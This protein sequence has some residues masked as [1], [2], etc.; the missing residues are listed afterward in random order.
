MKHIRVFSFGSGV[1][2]VAVLALQKLHKLPKPYDY[3]V[4]ANV[5]NDSESP[6]TLQYLNDIVRPRGACVC[7]APSEIGG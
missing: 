3:F 6:D 5:G 7:A 2:S 1:Q 4:F